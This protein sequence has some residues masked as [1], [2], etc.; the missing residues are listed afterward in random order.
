MVSVQCVCVCVCVWEREWEI[1]YSKKIF[2]QGIWKE[3]QYKITN[4]N[5]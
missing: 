2:M 4:H 1:D 3:I 5:F